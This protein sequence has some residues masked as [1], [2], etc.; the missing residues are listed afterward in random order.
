LHNK[1]KFVK[2]G[3][4]ENIANFIFVSNNNLPIKIENG[5]RRYV[6]FK[7][8]NISK[9]NF[10]YFNELNKTFT[11]E[12]YNELYNNFINRDLTD[13]NARVIQITDI[14]NDMIESCQEV[15]LLFFEDNISKYMKRYLCNLAY[16][17]YL[18]YCKNENFMPFSNIKFGLKLKSVVDVYKTTKDYKTVRY[19]FWSYTSINIIKG[20]IKTI[21][22]IK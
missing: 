17:D 22:C 1:S 5:D 6:I 14:K 3:D 10:E 19:Y 16:F 12:F 15:W 8:S 13:F 9:N 21:R 7:T 20:S 11:H 2:A 4:I 18:K